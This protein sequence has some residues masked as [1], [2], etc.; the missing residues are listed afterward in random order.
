M[1]ELYNYENNYSNKYFP[2]QKIKQNCSP[3]FKI[4]II[5]KSQT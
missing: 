4:F 3:I 5:N 2:Y 1:I